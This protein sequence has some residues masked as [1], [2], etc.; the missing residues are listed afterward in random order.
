[1]LSFSALGPGDSLPGERQPQE[2]VQVPGTNADMRAGKG[3]HTN[4]RARMQGLV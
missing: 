2:E 4:V 3:G 1:M